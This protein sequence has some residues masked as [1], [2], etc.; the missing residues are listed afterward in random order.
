MMLEKSI[1]EI[2]N[3]SGVSE[4]TVYQRLCRLRIKAKMTVKSYFDEQM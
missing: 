3:E 4:N 1:S 2:A